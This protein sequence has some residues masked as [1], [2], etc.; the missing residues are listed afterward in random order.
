M[1]ICLIVVVVVV[2]VVAVVVVVVVVVVAVRWSDRLTGHVACGR[3]TIT[4]STAASL[5]FD[6]SAIPWCTET[7]R[8]NKGFTKEA[9]CL[10]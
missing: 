8:N 9:I 1:Y 10:Y 5:F 7:W 2:V 4:A 3:L 6:A